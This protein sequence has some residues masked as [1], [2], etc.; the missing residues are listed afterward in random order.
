MSS[1]L[2]KSLFAAILVLFAVY[3]S[4]VLRAQEPAKPGSSSPSAQASGNAQIPA[5]VKDEEKKSGAESDWVR[6]SGSIKWI[7]RV[8]GLTLDQAYWLCFGINFAIVFFAI[9]AFMRKKLP[10]AF[11][12]RTAGIKKGIEEAQ[13][14]SAEARSR[15]AEVEARLSRIDADIASMRA[16]ADENAKAD[17]QRIMASA[18]EERRRIVSSAEQ[19]ILMAANAARRELKSYVAELAVDLAEKRIRVDKHADE[20]L[21][22]QFSAQLGKDGN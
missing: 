2:R 4:Q 15:L 20:A 17:E 12:A 22:R 10:G 6:Q 11:R 3:P 16:E 7:A 13:K 1:H 8:T 9:V 14:A 21:V 5:E 19:E 18:E